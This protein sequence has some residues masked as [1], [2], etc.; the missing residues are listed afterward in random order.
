MARASD[1]T[2]TIHSD[3]AKQGPDRHRGRDCF[4]AAR[5]EQRVIDFYRNLGSTF[6]GAVVSTC[7]LHA[8]P[9]ASQ[10]RPDSCPT[11]VTVL[12]ELDHS[13]TPILRTCFASI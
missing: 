3:R 2:R 1:M 11:L 5:H 8:S 12:G 13:N 9:S 10:R 4:V 7:G 6:F